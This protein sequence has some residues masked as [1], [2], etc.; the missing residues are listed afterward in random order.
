LTNPNRKFGFF[1][2]AR[3]EF[4]RY[5]FGGGTRAMR[6]INASNCLTGTATVSGFA[7]MGFGFGFGLDIGLPLLLFF[8]LRSIEIHQVFKFFFGQDFTSTLFSFNLCNFI[9]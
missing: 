9:W 8:H 7:V 5:F 6:D 2:N 3:R 1:K 4:F